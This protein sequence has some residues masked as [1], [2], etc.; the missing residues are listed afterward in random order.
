MH[1]SRACR[2]C[3]PPGTSPVQFTLYLQAELLN[4]HCLQGEDEGRSLV[5]VTEYILSRDGAKPVGVYA[6]YDSQQQLQYIGL[7]RNMVLAIKVSIPQLSAA[8]LTQVPLLEHRSQHPA[9]VSQHNVALSQDTA[10]PHG[11]GCRPKS[12]MH[13][14]LHYAMPSP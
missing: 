5:Q 10:W 4:V 3:T 9:V 8:G 1:L 13:P 11:M 2:D 6:L 12:C 7:A 14:S